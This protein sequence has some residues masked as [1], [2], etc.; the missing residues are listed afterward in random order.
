LPDKDAHKRIA[1]P[2]IGDLGVL[3]S[4]LRDSL[5]EN[6]SVEE[7]QEVIGEEY[8]TI[9][10][11]ILN[12]SS[13]IGFT[14]NVDEETKSVARKIKNKE[15]IDVKELSEIFKII[16]HADSNDS[17]WAT[18][19]ISSLDKHPNLAE[20]IIKSNPEHKRVLMFSMEH[21]FEEDVGDTSGFSLDKQIDIYLMD[22]YNVSD[23]VKLEALRKFFS[24]DIDK[25]SSLFPKILNHM[26]K[27][28]KGRKE[29]FEFIT[30]GLYASEVGAAIQNLDDEMLLML[31]NAPELM[32]GDRGA[33]EEVGDEL[34]N[35]GTITRKDLSLKEEEWYKKHYSDEFDQ[36][37][38]DEHSE[39]QFYK[40]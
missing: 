1:M 15:E 26:L 17:Y 34:E 31:F 36:E 33:L 10:E 5:D 30:K 3:K 39:E 28:D 22:N 21:Y 8:D 13:K 7:V 9:S 35:R 4:E 38:Q 24:E 2:T 14:D 16:E 19:I 40:Y 12:H 18:L 29:V 27:F 32:L 11:A 25:L 20:T 6:M 23:E 37:Y